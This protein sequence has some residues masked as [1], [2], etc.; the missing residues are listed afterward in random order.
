MAKPNYFVL[1]SL[2]DFRTRNRGDCTWNTSEGLF[3]LAINHKPRLPKLQQAS[4]RNKWAAAK[5]LV[6]DG[7]KQLGFLSG[8]KK[9][10]LYARDW[11]Q[12]IQFDQE[13]LMTPPQRAELKTPAVAGPVLVSSE[14]Q[15][16]ETAQQLIM[17]PV[18]ASEDTEFVDLHFGGDGRV[19]VIESG[20]GK[21]GLRLVHLGRRWQMHISWEDTAE[22]QFAPKRCWVDQHQRIWVAS[23]TELRVYVGEPLPHKYQPWVDRFEPLFINPNPL[24][25]VWQSSLPPARTLMAMCANTTQV[26]LLMLLSDN[27]TQ[28]II[29]FDLDIH[30]TAEP[31]QRQLHGLPLVV[32]IA[33]V[34]RDRVCVQCYVHESEVKHCDF[35][36]LLLEENDYQIEKRSYPMHSQVDVRFVTGDTETIRY[37][38]S[39]GP[40]AV[41]PLPQARYVSEGSA[42]LNRVLDSGNP[43]TWWDR[44]YLDACIPL[45]CELQIRVNAFEE[46]NQP[47]ADWQ[48]QAR[49]LKLPI[50]SELPFYQSRFDSAQQHQGLYEILLQRNEG[51]VR[52]IRGRY[53]Q[54]EIVMRGDGRHTPTIESMRVAYPRVSWQELYLPQL[55]RQQEDVNRES[56][57][58][59]NGADF[60]ER[61][62]SLLDGLLRPIEK[63]IISAETWLSPP[64]VPQQ[65]LPTL[66]GMLGE[67]LPTSWPETRA[68][69]WISCLSELQKRKGTFAGLCLALDIATDGAVGRGQ[70]VPVENYLMRRTMAT[71]LGIDM[72]DADHPLTLGTRQSGNSIVG[73]TLFL[74]DDTARE[75]VTLLAPELQQRGDQAIEEN[76][77]DHYAH[78]VSIVVHQHAASFMHIIKQIA[79]D[80]VPAALETRIIETD[81]PFVLGLSPLLGIDTYLEVAEQARQVVLNDTYL[82]REGLMRNRVAFSPRDLLLG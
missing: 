62:L 30:L 29:S 21:H 60:R 19:A 37:L 12:K 13:Q 82:G 18:V 28:E 59:A 56:R 5:V 80:F 64:G 77:L 44:I 41:I 42:T 34:E 76:F 79:D 31:Q 75:F 72:D 46:F 25:M 33:S 8:D 38:S 10:L 57:G 39:D 36:F 4:A 40:K 54:I 2:D 61:V 16:A 45:G 63:R 9:T 24:R 52:D 17:V 65:H 48:T 69:I 51:A 50:S 68:R 53:L 67:T 73:D 70:I 26:H 35:V 49:P 14:A 11:Q 66:A 32:D 55:F 1:N 7:F 27:S 6:M 71:I 22:Q 47:Q 58:D 15:E 81:K 78:R 74:S 43:D 23:D 3:H 20:V